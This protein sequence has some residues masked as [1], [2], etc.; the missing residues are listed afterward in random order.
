[1]KDYKK[2]VI[3]GIFII[4]M[5]CPLFLNLFL[6][7]ISNNIANNSLTES[8]IQINLEND[9][10]KTIPL[11]AGQS[12]IQFDAGVHIFTGDN[13]N[14]TSITVHDFAREG[15]TTNSFLPD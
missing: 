13:A 1:M 11:V 15:L 14:L 3:S 8:P 10:N 9:R 2:K 4:F 6:V 5:V 7:N 12:S